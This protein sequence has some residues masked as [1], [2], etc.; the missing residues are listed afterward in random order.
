MQGRSLRLTEVREFLS[1]VELGQTEMGPPAHHVIGAD[2]SVH[3]SKLTGPND[4]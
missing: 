1:S 4:I 3:L 2:D